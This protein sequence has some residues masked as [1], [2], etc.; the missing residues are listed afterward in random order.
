MASAWPE[1]RYEQWSE[2]CDTLHAHT[3]VLG[4]LAIAL[5]PHEP[6]LQHAALRL[7]ARGYET[8][9]LPGAP[10]AGGT[11]PP[12]CPPPTGRARS[13]PRSTCTSTRRSPSTPAAPPPVC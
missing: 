4:K 6:Q 1:L 2:T 12:R 11:S 9:P 7:T 5:A 10:R 13:S 3:Q 8:A